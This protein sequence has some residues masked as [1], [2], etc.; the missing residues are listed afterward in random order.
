M[1]SLKKSKVIFLVSE[2]KFFIYD[3]ILKISN[4]PH[5]DIK[6]III[7]EYNEKIKRKLIL[8]LLFGL[9]NCLKLFYELFFKRSSNSI[10]KLCKNKKIKFVLTN[11]LNNLKIINKIKKQNA[12]LIINLNVMKILKKNLVDKF[13]KKLINFHPGILPNYRGLY[14]TFYKI[15]NKDKYFGITSHY[16]QSK[17]DEGPIISIIKQK[18]NGRKLFDCYKIIYTKM[19]YKLFDETL[20]KKGKSLKENKQSKLKIYKSPTLTQI[21]KYKF[22]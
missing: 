8:S 13:K 20:K 15:I 14:S 16:M 12:D 5:I 19:I 21:L 11:N 3:F 2:D 22:L 1:T 10:T 6:L 7:Q 18:I 4:N 17:I 9:R